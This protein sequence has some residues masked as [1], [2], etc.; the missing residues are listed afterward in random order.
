MK[1][2]ALPQSEQEDALTPS[3][4]GLYGSIHTPRPIRQAAKQLLA[5]VASA[6]GRGDAGAS[7]EAC[8]GRYGSTHCVSGLVELVTI[9]A[10]YADGAPRLLSNK[11][12]VFQGYR[13][14]IVGRISRILWLLS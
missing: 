13:L 10:G 9:G 3:G 1:K 11:G 6:R 7:S 5:N 12:H 14:P 8:H 4:V 2:V